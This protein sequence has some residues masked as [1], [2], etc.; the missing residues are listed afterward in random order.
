MVHYLENFQVRD[1]E[2]G[3]LET[4]VVAPLRPPVM[5]ERVTVTGLVTGASMM[6]MLAVRGI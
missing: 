3:T 1:A 5:R 2:A 6:E 4:G